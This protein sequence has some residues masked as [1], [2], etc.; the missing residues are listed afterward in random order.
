MKYGRKIASRT[1][2]QKNTYGHR[3]KACGD[4]HLSDKGQCIL[5]PGAVP[6]SSFQR[7]HK[8]QLFRVIVT[9]G[10]DDTIR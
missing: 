1:K 3:W 8:T 4:S 10:S 6:I 2:N 9:Y 7:H 5:L